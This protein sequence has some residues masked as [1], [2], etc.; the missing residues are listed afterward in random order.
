MIFL[1]IN[2]FLNASEIP[3]QHFWMQKLKYRKCLLLYP[4]KK[5]IFGILI[6]AS[7]SAD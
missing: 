1:Y 5:G 4:Q 3:S 2:N 7:K 6:F